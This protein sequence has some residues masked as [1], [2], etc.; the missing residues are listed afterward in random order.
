MPVSPRR[1]VP[2]WIRPLTERLSPTIRNLVIAEAVLFGLYVMV[3][4]LREP[5]L[6]HLALGPRLFAGE[7]WQLGTSL[8][9]HVDPLGFLLGMVGL[10]F[11]GATI[12][13]TLGRRRFLLIFFGSGLVANLVLAGLMVAFATPLRN[14]GCGDSVLALFVALGVAYGRTP[15][16]VWGSLALPARV[17][18]WILV[19]WSVLALVL[20]AQWP[21]LLSTLVAQGL[22]YVLAGGRLGAVGA[23]L[24]GLRGKPRGRFDV[25]DGGRSKRDKKY[26]N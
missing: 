5:I 17:L 1:P 24:A 16:R 6:A 26:V 20:Q 9:V 19:A 2:A 3:A 21:S 18:A 7:V 14:L 12:E 22:A 13:R 15:V 23:F 10:W 25:M 11:V 4:P 8:F